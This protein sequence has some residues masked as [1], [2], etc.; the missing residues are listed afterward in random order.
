MQMNQ[1]QPLLHTTYKKV[2]ELSASAHACNP[3]YSGGRD[4]EDCSLK[5]ARTKGS[6]DPILKKPLTKKEAGGVAQCVGPE[7]KPQYHKKKKINSKWI[8]GFNVRTKILR[9]KPTTISSYSYIL[10]SGYDM[11]GINNKT[12][13]SMGLRQN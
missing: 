12:D 4:Q 6:R 11:K 10:G 13:T 1:V 3:S 5:S 7:F 8:I 9:R 2:K